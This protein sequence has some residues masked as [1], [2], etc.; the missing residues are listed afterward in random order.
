MFHVNFTIAYI[1]HVMPIN[2]LLVLLI[3]FYSGY[4]GV[5]KAINVCKQI[6]AI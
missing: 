6:L 5:G 4:E 3:S 2:Q 1:E